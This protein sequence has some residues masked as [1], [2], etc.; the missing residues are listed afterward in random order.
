MAHTLA[1]EDR[2]GGAIVACAVSCIVLLRSARGAGHGSCPDA[3]KARAVVFYM[4]SFPP[5]IAIR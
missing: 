4:I 2:Q 3:A 5:P 1:T